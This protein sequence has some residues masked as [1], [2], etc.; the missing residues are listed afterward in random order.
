[1]SKKRKYVKKKN[2]TLVNVLLIGLILVVT[3]FGGGEDLIKNKKSEPKVEQDQT[4]EIGKP[5][6]IIRGFIKHVSDGD[7]VILE[8][9]DGKEQKI[10]LDGIDAPEMGQS[11]G[12]ESKA[13]LESLVLNKRVEVKKIGVDQYKR[14]LGVL[15]LEGKDINKAM[16]ENGMAWQYKY[17]KDQSYS[18]LMDKARRKKINIWSDPNAQNPHTWRKENK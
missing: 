8:D 12:Q 16:L 2:N 17:N 7:T 3:Y 10:R 6:N 4:V 13:F 1:M 15:S 14:V 11:Y 5:K 9:E 18:D